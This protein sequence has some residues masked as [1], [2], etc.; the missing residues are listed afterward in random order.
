MQQKRKGWGC[1]RKEMINMIEF[2][3]EATIRPMNVAT[4]AWGSLEL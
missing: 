2:V 4:K 1:N 3:K